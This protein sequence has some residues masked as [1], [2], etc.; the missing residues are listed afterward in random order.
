MS[1]YLSRCR[2]LAKAKLEFDLDLGYVIRDEV[3]ILLKS[4]ERD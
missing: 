3:S 2:D 4:V 1:A